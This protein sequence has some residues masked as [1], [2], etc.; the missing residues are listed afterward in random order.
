MKLFLS[1]GFSWTV[2]RGRPIARCFQWEVNQASE[3]IQLPTWRRNTLPSFSTSFALS[4]A[5]LECK[6]CRNART[7][8]KGPLKYTRE[9]DRIILELRFKRAS[10]L[11][12]QQT[13]SHR[14]KRGV[15][16]RWRKHLRPNMDPDD[17]SYFPRSTPEKDRKLVRMRE[18][19]FAWD[20]L[21]N[22]FP[23]RSEYSME[24]RSHRTKRQAESN[25]T[26]KNLFRNAEEVARLLHT[27]DQELL[28][29]ANIAQISPERPPDSY[30]WKYVSLKSE[31][32]P[33]VDFH[34]RVEY[35]SLRDV[36]LLAPKTKKAVRR[37]SCDTVS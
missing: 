35:A 26:R 19:G 2:V 14:T 37:W 33:I 12:I 18:E 7:K 34:R 8:R 36:E 17:K 21:G 6:G 22:H 9:E 29:W 1:P 13:L 3:R 4:I 27:R 16:N 23:T 31:L 25:L 32:K 10:W 28:T 5:N 15:I 11:R 20:T 30:Y 24:I